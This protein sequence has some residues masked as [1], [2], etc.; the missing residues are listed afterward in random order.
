MSVPLLPETFADSATAASS[1]WKSTMLMILHP[2]LTA[3]MT[4]ISSMHVMT[5]T[6]T[7]TTQINDTTMCPAI[8][9]YNSFAIQV[10]HVSASLPDFF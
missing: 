7:A 2:P 3:K 1:W 8:L 6:S 9:N 5:I 4:T 10:L